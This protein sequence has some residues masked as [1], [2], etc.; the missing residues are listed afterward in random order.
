MAAGVSGGAMLAPVRL[1][2]RA[3]LS[4]LRGVGAV[5]IFAARGIVPGRDSSAAELGRQLVRI[6]WLSLPVVGLTALFTGAALALQIN[7][8]GERFKAGDVVPAIVAIGMVRE[9]GP[10]LGGLMVAARVASSIAAELGSMRVSEQIDALVTLST[11]PVKWLVWPRIWA[12][13]LAVPVLVGVGDVI[14]I[15]GGWIVGTTT[16][17]FTS[18][19]YL[20]SSWAYLESW[21]VLSGL[22]KGAGF[23]L[24]VALAGTWCGIHAGRGAE[25]VG[26]ATTTAVVAASVAILA[27]NFVMTGLFFT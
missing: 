24:I 18:A 22:I 27:A 19:R 14:G 26:R 11:D 21:D 10:V 5:V 1:T 13:V 9:L 7:A 12:A 8:G 20:S 15:M 3:T 16:L 6:G 17:G 23:G 25:G 2:G 4:L